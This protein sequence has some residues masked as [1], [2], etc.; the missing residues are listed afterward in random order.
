PKHHRHVQLD[1]FVVMP[2]HLHGIIIL[3]DETGEKHHELSEII[4]GFKT[5]SSRRINQMRRLRGVSVWQRDY[6]DRILRCEESLP[7]IRQYIENN[8]QKWVE[9]EENQ[10]NYLSNR[11]PDNKYNC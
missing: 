7:N 6:Y 4:R 1:S 2:N 10:Q 3:T 11:S 8:P 9:D 5:F